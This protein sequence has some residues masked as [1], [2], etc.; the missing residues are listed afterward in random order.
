M[1]RPTDIAVVG[2]GL[3]YPDA[4]TPQQFWRNIEQGLVAIRELTEE[5]LANAALP[6]R[7]LNAPGFVKMGATLPGV[8]DWAADFFGY[9]PKEAETIDPQQRIFLEA[10]WEALEAAG[11]PPHDGGPRTGVFAASYAGHY[12]AAV[13]NAKA[14]RQGLRAAIDDLD[15][16]VGG[17]PDFLTS[18]AAYKL[19]LRGPAV[20]IQT[21]CSASLYALHYAT[22]SLLSGEVDIALAGGATVIEPFLGYQ[23][24]PG[25]VLSEDGYCRSYDA[26]STGTIYS[27]GVGVVALRR[28][29]DALADG[30]PV[31]AVVR[32]SAVGNDGGDRLGYVAPSPVGVSEVVGSALRV[33]DVPAESFVYAEGHGTGT[34]V[35]DEIELIALRRAF[36]AFTRE[37]GYCALGSTMTNIGHSGPA[38]GIAGFIKAV[39]IARTGVLPPHPMFD[40][41]RTPDVMADS[42]FYV[43]TQAREATRPDRHVL[44]N[45]MGV[46]GTNASVVLGAPPA[47]TR[48][49]APE[50]PVV[51]LTVSARTRSE[52]DEQCRRLADALETGDLPVADVAHTLRVGRADFAERRVV[53]AAADKLAA[54]L[55]LPRPPAARTQRAE[56]R[57]AVVVPADA[58]E[59]L[60]AALPGRTDAAAGAYEITLDGTD[61]DAVEKA[62]TAAWLNG[63]E[64]D[65]T[66]FSGGTGRRV[67]L[68]TYPFTR[69]RHWLLD[70]IDVLRPDTP[71]AP[72][73]TAPGSG[74]A[75]PLEHELTEIWQELF[76][77][78]S[79]ALDDEFG[80]LGG[81]SLMSVQM[82]LEV[83]QRYGVLVNLHRAGGSRATI[84][85]LALIVRGLLE[86]SGIEADGVDAADG[87]GALV[88]QDLQLPIGELA[89]EEAPGTDVLLT[90]A[91]GYLGAFLLADLVRH[92]SGRVYCVVRAEDEAAGMARLRA[93]AEK[94]G[95]PEPDPDRVHVVP[96]D[97]KDIGVAC[98]LY[99]DG[100]LAKRIGH[101]IHCAA[102]V[103]F[104]EPYRVLR[105]SNVL[106]LVDLLAWAR[107]KGIRD[108]SYVST[109][110]AAAPPDENSSTLLE[111]REQPLNPMLGGY[112]VSKWVGERLLERADE[113]GMRCRVFRPGM[114]MAS[115]E[116]GACN[117][118]DLIWFVLASGLAVGAHPLDDQA[119]PVSPVNVLSRGLVELALSP[120]SAG[121]AFHLVH[122]KSIS[123]P[124]MFELL[125]EVGWPTRPMPLAD[126]QKL[127]G[128]EA[129]KSGNQVM[130]TTALWEQE[131]AFHLDED[132]VQ[133][134]NWRPWLRRAKVDPNVTGE[135]L[136]AGLRYLAG[137]LPEIAELLPELVEKTE[138]R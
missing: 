45:S 65:W 108:F 74:A 71:A 89:A 4:G 104:T 46:G 100:E 8:T 120:A 132:G 83:Q 26:S 29:S 68:P 87:D 118:R 13:F 62:L 17:Q 96:A 32:G 107:S 54:A 134:R 55:R 57:R 78:E 52:L 36:R 137:R 40:K 116:S 130:S 110:A 121:R 38:A 34:A 125:G 135:Q 97:L 124:R 93:N 67:E 115:S 27:S 129:I 1:T 91:T 39:N 10:A 114:I 117:D 122:E 16:T 59:A 48:A 33:A 82:A 73:E 70:R 77:V 9:T 113:D 51:R 24:V 123:L 56:P 63:V 22:L 127:V 105:D 61:D 85:K 31:L 79:I 47:P 84:R 98:R 131:D 111:T 66:A 95:L 11:H 75:D 64:V 43:T 5:Q 69:K 99:R 42:P 128:D 14:R 58:P 94:F 136:L 103:V 41:P 6:D 19:G 72:A 60:V 15:L 101:I 80:A 112:G 109:L 18:R 37:T 90:G 86:G 35:G 44:V 102:Q 92:S 53:T 23:H 88:D 30:D 3:R 20:S 138:E 133:A 76:G 2:V 49:P 28:L 50:R 21:G 126:W 81:S 12:S 106:P 7:V 119:I 25:G